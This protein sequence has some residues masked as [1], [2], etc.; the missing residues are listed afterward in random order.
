MLRLLPPLKRSVG[1]D[2]VRLTRPNRAKGMSARGCPV[3]GRGDNL[4]APMRDR[5]ERNPPR[6]PSCGGRLGRRTSVRPTTAPGAS[7]NVASSIA[8]ACQ[9]AMNNTR[10]KTGGSL[11]STSRLLKPPGP[12]RHAHRRALGSVAGNGVVAWLNHLV[13]TPSAELTLASLSVVTPTPIRPQCRARAATLTCGIGGLSYQ[14]SS[15]SASTYAVRDG[16]SF[17]RAR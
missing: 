12:T 1:V 6:R 9:H 15:M 5:V 14:G 11:N 7:S 16:R 17:G 3:A 4:P 13:D 2:L 10:A 8:R